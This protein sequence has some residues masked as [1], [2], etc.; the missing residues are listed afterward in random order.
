MEKNEKNS[1]SHRDY[2]NDLLQASVPLKEGQF[3][4]PIEVSRGYYVGPYFGGADKVGVDWFNG[5]V[6]YN[7]VGR[8]FIHW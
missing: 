3:A 5:G 2:V 4:N 7:Q 1:I 6:Q 8:V